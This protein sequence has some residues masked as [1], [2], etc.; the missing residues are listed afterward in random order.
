[1]VK[2]LD[3]DNKINCSANTVHR[4]MKILGLKPI[5][6]K[7]RPKYVK[8]TYHKKFENLLVRD[9]TATKPTQKWCT[10]FTYLKL[11]DSSK[12]YNC[13]ILELYDRS[14]VATLNGKEII[15]ELAIHTLQI[16]LKKNPNY[17]HLILH[18][19]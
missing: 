2:H 8:G 19:D 6:I 10:D 16:A 4:Y 11:T 14:I 7:K 17:N 3:R 9:F 18:S 1:M 15:A 5:T 13:S 12:G